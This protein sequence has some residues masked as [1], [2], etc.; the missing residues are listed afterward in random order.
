MNN[1]IIKP[2]L[3]HVML[4]YINRPI[5]GERME[6][7]ATVPTVTG[8]CKTVF[9]SV[10]PFSYQLQEHLEPDLGIYTREVFI[11]A[12]HIVIGKEHSKPCMN[13]LAKGSMMLKR[14]LEDPGKLVQAGD[15][16]VTFRTD[17]GV[18]KI[19][20]T[21]EDCIFINVFSNVATTD[22]NLIEDELIVR[23]EEFE[24]YKLNKKELKCH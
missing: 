8:M 14:T 18:Q 12:G 15:A 11:P 2:F 23:D 4:L 13:I 22:I 6:V 19:A 10:E 1:N 21:L 7:I 17:P 3:G 20:Y 5:I 16:T 9:D 24:M